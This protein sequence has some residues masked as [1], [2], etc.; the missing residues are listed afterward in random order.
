MGSP[1]PKLE[2][3]ASLGCKFLNLSWL[4]FLMRPRGNSSVLLWKRDEKQDQ[5]WKKFFFWLKR[6]KRQRKEKP[7]D[8]NLN[9]TQDQRDCSLILTPNCFCY[10]LCLS[11]NTCPGI[12][13][14]SVLVSVPTDPE[15]KFAVKTKEGYMSGPHCKQRKFTIYP[16]SNDSILF[17][18]SSV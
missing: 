6:R 12:Q 5:L 9:L 4:L 18:C 1:S 16:K 17:P 15:N 7:V 14:L 3:W 8:G 13:E 11:P 10:Y 2:K